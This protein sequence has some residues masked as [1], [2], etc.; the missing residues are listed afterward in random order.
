MAWEA[1]KD[2]QRFLD[3]PTRSSL[4]HR[5][6]ATSTRTRFVIMSDT[7]GGHR[8]VK[9]P[10]GDVL[11]HAGDLTTTGQ[12]HVLRDLAAFFEENAGKFSQIV[13]IAGNHDVTFHEEFYEENWSHFHKKKLQTDE[14]KSVLINCPSCTYLQDSSCTVKGGL[15]VYGSPW[16][17]FFWG[18]AFN[19]QRGEPIRQK[20]NLIPESTDVLI[21]H[22]PPLGRRDLAIRARKRNHSNHRWDPTIRAGCV[23]LLQQVQ[24]R[25]RPRLHVF[26][27]I[28]ED[29]GV[30]YDGTTLYVNASI[31]DSD[32]EVTRE[33][34]V[35]DVPHDHTQPAVVVQPVCQV[36]NTEL[37]L[38]LKDRNFLIL[39]SNMDRV[40][41]VK[42]LPS[43]NELLQK[44]RAYRT[45]C[46]KLGLK[47]ER[48]AKI[49]L[50]EALSQMYVESFN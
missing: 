36:Q 24:C 22:G 38:W 26:G 35:V 5:R 30:S 41:D 43:C 46:E 3:P 50:W 14:C 18:W 2:T 47:E 34:L 40:H 15:Q 8:E 20:W 13:C 33:C 21:T 37:Q 16:T 39:A 9:L 42:E 48:S 10:S 32:Y 25:V 1:C 27:H 31:V 49:Q 23:D 17:P 12:P 11:I 29:W 6:D 45:L 28:H 19:L 4:D 7:H 44:E